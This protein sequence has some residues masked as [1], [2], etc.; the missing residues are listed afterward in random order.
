MSPDFFFRYSTEDRNL[1]PI[2]VDTGEK[3]S[4]KNFAFQISPTLELQ[5]ILEIAL[6]CIWATAEKF[7][8]GCSLPE[9]NPEIRE[10]ENLRDALGNV[11]MVRTPGKG[12]FYYSPRWADFFEQEAREIGSVLKHILRRE[13]NLPIPPWHENTK[14][15]DH[16]FAEVFKYHERCDRFFK[17][18]KRQRLQ[19]SQLENKLKQVKEKL[20]TPDK[21]RVKKDARRI[22]SSMRNHPRSPSMKD[23]EKDV[24]LITLM[25]KVLS[26]LQRR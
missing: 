10:D 6:D 11:L 18:I 17:K 23:D 16:L 4:I 21:S 25:R 8:I 26:E 15:L 5:A 13:E 7:R 2:F 22:S 20:K 12:Q 3:Q 19:I 9:T 1:N 14:V 24:I